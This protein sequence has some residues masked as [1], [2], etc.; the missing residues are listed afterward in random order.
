MRDGDARFQTCGLYEV[1]NTLILGE[2]L[3]LTQTT[4]LYM[5]YCR[6]DVV[7]IQYISHKCST[8]DIIIHTQQ[9]EEKDKKL[10]IVLLKIITR[11]LTTFEVSG[12]AGIALCTLLFT[13][14]V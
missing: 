14:V 8:T 5:Y 2:I 3:Y 10:T 4:L 9:A 12:V 11:I 6:T 7:N 1:E 13:F